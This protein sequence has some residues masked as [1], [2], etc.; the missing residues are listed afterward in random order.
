MPSKEKKALSPSASS[1]KSSSEVMNTPACVMR[2]V[3][4]TV[5]LGTLLALTLAIRKGLIFPPVRNG[6]FCGDPSLHYPIKEESVSTG[7][8]VAVG[9][10]A[11]L[12]I[13]C[14][15]EYGYGDQNVDGSSSRHIRR[16]LPAA[17][18]QLLR[19]GK[20]FLFFLIG[21]CST[22]F[23]FELGKVTTGILR[24]NFMAVCRPN[25]TCSNPSEYHTNYA[26]V[27]ASAEE[28]EDARKSFPSGHA[29]VVSYMA[30]F[31]CAYL[32]KRPGALGGG[33]GGTDGPHLLVRPFIQLAA[34]SLA[35]VTSLSRVADHVHHLSDVLVGLAL[36]TGMALWAAGLA[37]EEAEHERR[38]DE[39]EEEDEEP[40][41]MSVKSTNVVV[42]DE[43]KVNKL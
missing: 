11:V 18:T 22:V 21:F 7:I 37:L 31:L 26:C 14:A 20:V 36:G 24:P 25:V 12:A 9:S 17:A 4:N 19:G 3:V 23:L 30:V 5:G 13:A 43:P 15:T 33:G 6:F 2:Y 38:K 16:R 39:R 1:S 10:I 42:E 40:L 32:S 35:W 29:A 34:L 41:E 27:G 8:I 28:E